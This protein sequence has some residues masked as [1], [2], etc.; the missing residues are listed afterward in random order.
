[1]TQA[2]LWAERRERLAHRPTIA[3]GQQHSAFVSAEGRLLTCAGVDE[4]DDEDPVGV[5]HGKEVVVVHVAVPTVVPGLAA[6]RVSSVA[7]STLHTLALSEDGVVY[8]CGWGA[9]G[10]LG[11][12]DEED[13]LTP[14]VIEGLLGV[15]ACAVA[16]GGHNLVLGTSG[17]VY[18]FGYGAYGQLGH[19]DENNQLTRRVIEALRSVR[20]CVV[21]TGSAHSLVLGA[22]GEVYSFGD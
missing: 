13:Q 16:G 7:A 9:D 21:A 8:S 5:G 14:R 22:G 6:V 18:S 10:R 4:D 20:V 12:G 15:C 11:H 19:G 3:A 2:L 17:V 1:M